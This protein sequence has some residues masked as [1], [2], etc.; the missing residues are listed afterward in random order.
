MSDDANNADQADTA[1]RP[2]RLA[3]PD[4]RTMPRSCATSTREVVGWKTMPLDMG[5]LRRLRHADAPMARQESGE[6]DTPE[7]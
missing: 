7:E 4:R 6:S 2:D 5:G 1:T 3:G